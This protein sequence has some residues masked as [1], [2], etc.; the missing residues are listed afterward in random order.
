MATHELNRPESPES[1]STPRHKGERVER[2]L[3]IYDRGEPGPTLIVVGGMHGNERGGVLAVRRVLAAMHEHELPLRGRLIGL[4]G[5][6][7]ALAHD[8]RYIENDLNRV[9]REDA[10]RR[11]DRQD[12]NHD[13]SEEREQRGLLSE[14][15]KATGAGGGAG[16]VLLDL[17][18]SSA[19][20]APFSCMGDTLKNRRV[21]LSIPIP[22]ILGLEE[23]IE[24]S[25]L[26]YLSDR[27]HISMAV[28]GGQH[29]E[30]TTAENLE[31]AVWMALVSI[32]ALRAEEVPG[33]GE[34]Y[35]NLKGRA[36]GRPG[37]VEVLYRHHIEPDDEFVMEPGFCNFDRIE[38]GQLLARD[39][40]GE[41]RSPRNG[42]LLLPLYQGLGEDGFFLGREVR[43][44]WL[45]LSTVVR[46][47]RLG[48]LLR[49]LPGVS[50][51]PE[52]DDTLIVRAR[53]ARFLARELFHL[54]G[55]R[56]CRRQGG[57]LVF[58]R[59]RERDPLP[60]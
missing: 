42:I 48:K 13:G 30:P 15:R 43:R 45:R 53:V 1:S 36:R 29:E 44:F 34:C 59:R 55:Y 47:L 26:E 27:G 33:L 20:G 38:K 25:L 14:I 11:L 10:V 32:G 8:C 58:R 5:N 40:H 16:T 56:Q 51:H 52:R 24:G 18:S 9:W 22:V 23:I 39:R 19:Q 4:A 60:L 35:R 41:V 37:V 50:R 57:V 2:V 6:L 31:G 3:G 28:E 54:F 17:H 46:R 49:L 21:C 12:P 7:T